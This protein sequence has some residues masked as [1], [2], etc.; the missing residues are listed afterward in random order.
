MPTSLQALI[1]NRA[2]DINASL[3]RILAFALNATLRLA[4]RARAQRIARNLAVLQRSQDLTGRV[5]ISSTG[6]ET[7][8]GQEGQ[9]RYLR[10]LALE[11]ADVLHEGVVFE[12]V[13]LGKVAV[14]RCVDVEAVTIW[15]RGV[16]A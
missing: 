8:T 3:K 16:H 10:L 4:L 11:E 15:G 2:D 9:V 6:H 7:R 1:E 14:S 5:R 13:V 12:R